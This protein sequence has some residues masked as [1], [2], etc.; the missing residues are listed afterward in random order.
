MSQPAEVA[1]PEPILAP[2]D[3]AEMERRLE[4]VRRRMADEALDAVVVHCPDN[5]FYLTNFHNY[6]HERPFVLVVK[7]T[8]PLRFVV[9][10]LEEEHVRVRA[11]GE[12]E[13][14]HYFEFPAPAGEAWSDRLRDALGGATRVGVESVSPLQVI[15]EIPGET[16][17]SDVVDEA[18]MVKTDY[19]IGR[20][21]HA[22]GIISEG[23]RQLM[24]GCKPGELAISLFGNVT[25]AMTGLMLRDMP[26]ANILAS[27]FAA[28]VQPPSVSHDPHNFTDVFIQLEE[29]GPHVSV[30]NCRVNGYG[31]ELERS[32]FLNT[33]PEAARRPF[34]VMMEARRIA[35]ERTKPGE[36]MDEVD[37]AVRAH[38]EKHG[39]ADAMLHRTGHSF[40]VT[41]HEAPFL[42]VSYD[43]VIEP[44]MLFSIEPGIY[45]PGTGGFRHSDTVLVTESG[46]VSLTQADDAL[47][48]LVFQR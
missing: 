15:D 7:P 11:V 28:V 34:D 32:F 14:I 31:A 44:G 48:D 17:R 19:E 36:R 4:R 13:L 1:R 5:V 40:G 2:P 42:A 46:N 43:R 22:S 12:I 29:G 6:V 16:V 39:Y 21:A 26:N 47:E 10:L 27:S 30:I 35:F 38:F 25:R 18:R 3:I 20:I 23:H 41:G 9:P 8:G 33:A 24:A 45:L 37:R